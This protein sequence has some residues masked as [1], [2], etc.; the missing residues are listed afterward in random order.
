MTKDPTPLLV[1][2]LSMNIAILMTL[3]RILQVLT[4]GVAG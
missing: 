3:L 1:T 2:I 4:S